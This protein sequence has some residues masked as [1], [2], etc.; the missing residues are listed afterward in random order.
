[1]LA[2][3]GFD[4][5]A[6]PALADCQFEQPPEKHGCLAGKILGEQHPGQREIVRFPGLAWLIFGAKT[7]LGRPA[8]DRG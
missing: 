8:G 1:M 7:A 5:A 3:P 6:G 4:D 2:A